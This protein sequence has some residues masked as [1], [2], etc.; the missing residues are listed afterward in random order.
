MRER[1]ASAVGDDSV[2]QSTAMRA[3]GLLELVGIAPYLL[4]IAHLEIDESERTAL[5]TARPPGEDE[6][7]VLHF[8]VRRDEGRWWFAVAPVEIER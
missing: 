3:D 2:P 5:V 1:K 8:R 7:P 4:R 6:R